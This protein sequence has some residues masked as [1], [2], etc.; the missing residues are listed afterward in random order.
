M[1]EYHSKA[2]RNV[3]ILGHMDCGKTTIAEAALYLAGAID[4]KGEVE[5]KNTV[6]DYTV[7]EQ[8]RQ[9]SLQ[10]SLIPV[11]WNGH[12]IN[13]LD[14]PGSEEMIG[15]VDNVL[16]V[17]KGAVLVIDAGAGVEPGT[18]RAWEEL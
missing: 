15:E 8:V 14:V 2:I 4:K 11:E 5:K 9:T 6:S 12:K 16:S 1:R 7:E 17:V 10:A 3:A 18:E 13:L